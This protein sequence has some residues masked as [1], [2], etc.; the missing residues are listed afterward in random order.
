MS[1]TALLISL[2]VAK[3]VRTDNIA[4]KLHRLLITTKFGVIDQLQRDYFIMFTQRHRT[5]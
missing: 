3:S 4:N 1:Y 5:L 2:R